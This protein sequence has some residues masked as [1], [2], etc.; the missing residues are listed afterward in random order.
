MDLIV[1]F[2]LGGLVLAGGVWLAMRPTRSPDTLH[3]DQ[4]R[5]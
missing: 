2:T 1:L 5:A 3:D 4:R